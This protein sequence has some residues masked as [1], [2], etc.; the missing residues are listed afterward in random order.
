MHTDVEGMAV[1]VALGGHGAQPCGEL[2]RAPQLTGARGGRGDCAHSSITIRSAA[3]SSPHAPSWS[4]CA[5]S[6]STRGLRVVQ[7][8]VQAAGA[9][10]GQALRGAARALRSGRCPMAVAVPE[11]IPVRRGSSSSQNV[12]STMTQSAASAASWNS[13]VQRASAG[14][15]R[16]LRP[17]SRCRAAAGRP[18]TSGR[19]GPSA[20]Y[21]GPFCRDGHGGDVDR[22]RSCGAVPSRWSTPAMRFGCRG[23]APRPAVS[24]GAVPPVRVR[25]RGC[26]SRPPH[27][28]GRCPGCGR[29]RR[30]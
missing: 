13:S 25:W 20:A 7:V 10:A 5:A 30:R 8:G 1:V 23:T 19:P 4:C 26:R 24:A 2:L 28:A 27:A 17:V 3:T 6:G 14:A 16:R 11:E 15:Y 18:P 29:V 21:R 9:Q 22:C 12:P